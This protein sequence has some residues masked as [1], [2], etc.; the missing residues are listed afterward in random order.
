MNILLVNHYAGTPDLGMEFRPYYFAHEWQ[1][2]GH[3]VRI[4]GATYSHLRKVQPKSKGAEI[5]DGIYYYWIKTITYKSNGVKR[6]WSMFQFVFTLM[7][8]YKQ[9]CLEFVPDV[10]I[11]SSTYP[12]DNYPVRKIAKHYH[13]KYIYEVHDLW[14]LS[15]MELGGMS[16]FHPFIM[17]MQ[18][19]E[20]YAYKHVDAVVSILPKTE[21]Y[22]RSKGLAA[23]KFYCIPN[24]I[25]K[26]DW[27]KPMKLA[28]EY[29]ELL[30]HLHAEHKTIVGFTGSHGIAN[31][32]QSIIEAVG[33]LESNNI[34]LVL[35]GTG[36]KK[37]SL[38]R[39]VVEHGLKNVF[40]MP[41]VHKRMIPS[42]LAEMDILYIGWAKNPLYQYGISP[43]KI[44]DYAMA[45]KPIIHAVEAANDLVK[46]A[47]CGLSV[48]P[49]NINEI[50]EAILILSRMT[51]SEREQLG[52]KGKEY[53]L[54]NHT[55]NILANQF[56]KIIELIK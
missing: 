23:G 29:S 52:L 44:F 53:V 35:V 54:Q 41:P 14:P 30:T 39:Y 32:L 45:A 51:P 46:D 36:Q 3:Q 48:E 21:I 13:A 10:V 12:L 6:V 31:S 47:H 15:P 25:V 7:C 34:V 8:H 38:K 56:I 18:I 4:V 55:Y 20:N 5:I 33:K 42:L 26:E 40:F 1:K 49:D 11:A 37:E 43:N 28:D 9:I 24:G 50:S 19:A 2:M 22:M 16:K 27:D 17:M